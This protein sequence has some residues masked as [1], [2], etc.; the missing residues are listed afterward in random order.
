MTDEQE[1]MAAKHERIE[2]VM[3]MKLVTLDD[4]YGLPQFEGKP[5]GSLRWGHP[6]LVEWFGAHYSSLEAYD[7]WLKTEFSDVARK[8]AAGKDLVAD[9]STA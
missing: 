4:K 9:K 2:K 5:L 1:A 8:K 6:A 3:R 7:A